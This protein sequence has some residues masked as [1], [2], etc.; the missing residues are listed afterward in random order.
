M[1]SYRLLCLVLLAGGGI[2]CSLLSSVEV[3]HVKSSV[4]KPSNVAFYVDVRDGNEPVDD[5]LANNFKVYENDQLLDKTQSRLT[6]L[7]RQPF[8]AHH[9]LLL[10]DL[11]G[12]T[13]AGFGKLSSAVTSFVQLTRKF[14]SLSL[15]AFEGGQNLKHLGEFSRQTGDASETLS[16]LEN[17]RASDSSRNLNG[18]VVEGLKQLDAKLKRIGKPVRVGTLVVFSEGPDVAGR[19]SEEQLFDALDQTSHDVFVV[20]VQQENT[21]FLEDIGKSGVILAQSRDTL[22]IAFDELATALSDAYGRYYLVAYCSPSRAGKRRVRLEVSFTTPEGDERVGELE[23]D[24]D[25]TGF[26]ANCN[27]EAPPRFLKGTVEPGAEPEQREQPASNAPST[28]LPS[29]QPP[30]AAK[31]PPPKP[32]P[33]SPP[34]DEIVPPPDAPGYE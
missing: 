6:L 27:P 2:G 31:P 9:A 15:Y 32:A 25:A 29:T 7:D 23:R 13:N 18:A 1:S 3:L 8:S 34:E 10:L 22:K 19:V 30:G 21:D 5:L 4:Q 12:S 26:S 33:P 16:I 24:F 14:Q 28:P 11:S 17:Y 20:G